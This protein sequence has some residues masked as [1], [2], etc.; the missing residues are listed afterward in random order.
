MVSTP[1]PEPGLESLRAVM[2]VMAAVA[3]ERAIEPLLE[4]VGEPPWMGSR[5]A[6]RSAIFGI[7]ERVP[8]AAPLLVAACDASPGRALTALE[9]LARVRHPQALALLERHAARLGL[10][11]STRLELLDALDDPGTLRLVLD[12]GLA[13]DAPGSRASAVLLLRW[14]E[15]AAPLSDADLAD[16]CRLPDRV[17]R[18]WMPPQPERASPEPE[19][20]F[21]VPRF[22]PAPR[23]RP[24][25]ARQ[26]WRVDFE[27]VRQAARAA[28]QARG[29]TPP[30]PPSEPRRQD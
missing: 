20:R 28:L 10:S 13:A 7:S 8:A 3:D 26:D 23:P 25:Q 24:G 12:L 14:L 19:A 18:D 21:V 29:L 4:R 2:E 15:Q 22:D 9:A 30:S 17:G 5:A 27:N 11:P 1:P 16:I 6:A